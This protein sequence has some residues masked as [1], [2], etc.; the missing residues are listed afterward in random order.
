[1]VSAHLFPSKYLSIAFLL[2]FFSYFSSFLPPL[3]LSIF[4]F[5]LWC[6]FN[7]LILQAEMPQITGV[8][9]TYRIALAVS[10]TLD[11]RSPGCDSSPRD[12]L[13]SHTLCFQICMYELCISPVLSVFTFSFKTLFLP[14]FLLC[15]HNNWHSLW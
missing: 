2:S 6:F 9:L 4:A 13:A 1:M 10:H 15:S 11:V 7:G 12:S 5:V 8:A 14:L 3:P